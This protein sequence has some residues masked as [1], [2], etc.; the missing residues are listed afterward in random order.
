MI[1]KI[2]YSKNIKKATLKQVRISRDKKW[3]IWIFD[4][5]KTEYRGITTSRITYGNKPYVWYS[6]LVGY[7]LPHAYTI[8]IENIIGKECYIKLN[9]KN[10]VI[11]IIPIQ[12]SDINKDEDIFK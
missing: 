8:N 4:S 11:S 7:F 6:L 12:N 3:L 2:H 1:F 5:D 10:M 9:S